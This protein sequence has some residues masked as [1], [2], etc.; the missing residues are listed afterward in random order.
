MNDA[1]KSAD[2]VDAKQDGRPRTRPRRLFYLCVDVPWC[3]WPTDRWGPEPFKLIRG[4]TQTGAA[5][6]HHAR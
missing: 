3:I 6:G 4:R 5:G 1:R 2:Q